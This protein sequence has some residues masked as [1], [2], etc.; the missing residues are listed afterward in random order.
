MNRERAARYL[1]RMFGSHTGYVAL[2]AKR[3]D[4]KGMSD[5][6]RF[7]WP[8]QQNAILDWAEAESAKGYNVFVCPALRDNEGEPKAGAGVNLRW[9]WAEVDWQTVPETKRAEVEVRIKELATFKVR[10]GSTHDGRRNVH[11]YVKL[12][13]V[14]SGDEHYQLNTGLKEYLYADAKQ[15]DV[16]YLR[17]P[18]TFNHKTSDPVPVGMFK[19]TGRQI[20]NDDLNRLRTRAMRRATAPAEWERVDVSHVAKRWKRLAHTLPGCHPIA[21]RSKALWAIIGDLIKAGLTKD[22]IHTLM[23]DAPMALARDNPDR[24]HQ[25]IE[26]RW[27]DDAGL[28]VPLTDDEFWTARPELDRIR[29]FARARRVS[30]WAVFGV[31][32]T[33][34]VGE[35]P[36]YVVVPPLVGKAVSLNLFVGLVG[37]SGAGKD[38]AVGVAEDAIE[39]HGSV[40]V[41]NIGSGE[42]IAH[43][44][45]ERDGDKVRPHGTGSVLFQVGEIDTFASLT[46]RKGATLMPELRKMYMGER[47][48]FHYVDKTKRLPVEPHTYRAG[49]I[50]GIQPTRAGVLLED[51]D[52]GTPQRFLWMPTADP[53]APDERPDLPDRLAWRPPSF[54]SADPAQLYEMGVPDEVRKVIDRARLEQL[55]TGRSS[56]DGHSLLMRLK[57]ALALALLARRTAATGEDWWLAGLVMAK[58]DHTR[59]GVVEALAR[60]SASVNHQGARAEAARAAVVA[61]SLDDYAIR[62]TAKWAAKKLVGRG[63]VPH[64]ELRRDA[65]SRD[66]PHFDDAMDRL[67]EAGQVEARE[68]RDG[69]RSYRTTAGS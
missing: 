35:V 61:E 8:G 56:L 32:L 18:G 47:L 64:S 40:T 41:L 42:A 55:K 29:T 69:G 65:S 62:R 60:R 44:F 30:P 36:S 39:E 20:S 17:L 4:Q 50:A 48:G 22:E 68:A 3:T 53:D 19:G 49:L 45:V 11:V 15:S 57:V 66:R 2:A 34:V 13:R 58:S 51:A 46:Q 25:D 23:D 24:V 21:D 27:Q 16:S 33:R 67:I 37:E 52:G 28:P 7:R 10:S 63:W 14:V 59:A 6:K 38:S 31:V 1:R 26:K 43:A 9:L 54:N 5:R 12:P